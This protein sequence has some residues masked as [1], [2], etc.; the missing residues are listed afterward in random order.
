[1]LLT[2]TR[3]SF[4]ASILMELLTCKLHVSLSSYSQPSGGALCAAD[5][6]H[7]RPPREG[8]LLFPQ[9]FSMKII[10]DC[11]DFGK[12]G[13]RTPN[14]TSSNMNGFHLINIDGVINLQTLCFSS[15]LLPA[16]R[17]CIVCC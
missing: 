14:A 4:I 10:W 1:M 8:S 16:Q 3:M 9:N 11:N 2:G 12:I 15:Q 7:Q 13:Q 17:W 6:T 5:R